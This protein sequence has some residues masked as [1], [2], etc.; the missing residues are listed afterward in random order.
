MTWWKFWK[1]VEEPISKAEPAPLMDYKDPWARVLQCHC[2]NTLDCPYGDTYGMH[3]KV[4]S[5]C[6]CEDSYRP[7]VARRLLRRRLRYSGCNEWVET[8]CVGYELWTPQHCEH[9]KED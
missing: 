5:K 2:G 1:A 6:C 4:C 3:P 8:Q 7:M 9:A